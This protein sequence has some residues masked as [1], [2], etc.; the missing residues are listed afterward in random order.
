MKSIAALLRI[1]L[2][3]LIPI[4]FVYGIIAAKDFLFPIVLAILFAYLLYP[5]VNYL[6]KKKFPRALSIL[7]AILLAILVLG[8]IIL[9]FYTQLNSLFEDFAS[10]KAQA[11]ENIAAFQQTL[12]STFGLENVRLDSFLTDRIDRFFSTEGSGLSKI[13]SATTGTLS[14]LFILPVYVFLFLFFRTKLAFFILNVVKEHNKMITVKIL[15]SISTVAERYMG[16]VTIVVLILCVINSAGLLLIGIDY[17]ILLGITSAFFN[18]I[19]YFGTLMGGS[20][21]FLFVLFVSDQ[22][23]KFGIQVLILF[24]IVQF[25]ENNILTPNI[26]GGN[27][28]INPFFVIVGLVAG[29]T[30]WGVAGMVVVVPML[31][32]ARIALINTDRYKPYAYLLGPRKPNRP[33]LFR[34]I[35]SFFRNHNAG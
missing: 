29:A 9:L 16:G 28:K 20:V 2:I 25:T 24:V 10:L 5:I 8:G 30:V 4:L 19:P 12:K 27:V 23:I 26:V 33:S 35:K 34:R 17:A 6:D 18:F 13:F 14:K 31:A 32:M 15:R 22:P 7:S 1:A 21:P 3:L 11:G